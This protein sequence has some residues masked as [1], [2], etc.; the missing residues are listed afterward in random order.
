MSFSWTAVTNASAYDFEFDSGTAYSSVVSDISPT[1]Y[2]TTALLAS[3]G[4]HTWRVRGK[5]GAT[6]GSWSSTR[7]YSV[8][9]S[10]GTPTL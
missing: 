7:S 8:T 4:S 6:L 9:L 2:S 1:S 10:L 3:V 5:N